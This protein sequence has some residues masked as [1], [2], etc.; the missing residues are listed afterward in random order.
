MRT[1]DLRAVLL[2]ALLLLSA[3]GLVALGLGAS[4]A[5]EA[6]AE[7]RARRLLSGAA[8]AL[9]DGLTTLLRDADD[10]ADSWKPDAGL[11]PLLADVFVVDG[12]GNLR[13]PP[14][15]H[16][17]PLSPPAKDDVA[18]VRVYLNE[19]EALDPA[20]AELLLQTAAFEELTHPDLVGVLVM[21]LA[22]R[23]AAEGNPDR[24][25]Y[26]YR[27]MLT[28]L[29]SAR[30]LDGEALAPVAHL[31]L[32]AM[33]DGPERVDA[34]A[35]FA[36]CLADRAWGLPAL[37]RELMLERMAEEFPGSRLPAEIA[38]RRE[39]MDAF[40]PRVLLLATTGIGEAGRHW[41]HRAER[42]NGV[43]EI[44]GW[45]EL[46][47]GGESHAFGYRV[48][49]TAA[50]ERVRELAEVVARRF[51][52]RVE[53]D[54]TPAV[55]VGV[56]PGENPLLSSVDLPVGLDAIAAAVA[57]ERP[58]DLG[59][60]RTLHVAMTL[61]L[62]ASLLAGIL[63]SLRAVRRELDTARLRQ[64]LL[65]NT[66]HELRTPLTTIRMY[67]EMLAEEVLPEEKREEYLGLVL[68][69]SERMGRLVDDVLDLAKLTRGESAGDP[70]PIAP[71]ELLEAAVARW[72]GDGVEID[73]PFG[74]PLVRADRD[75]TVRVLLNLI[76]NAR[77]YSEG[78]IRLSARQEDGAVDLTVTDRGPGIPESERDRLFQR[79]YRSPRDAR[80]VRGV[81][82]GLVLAREIARAQGGDLRLVE[83]SAEG[84]VF[85]LRLP[86]AGDGGAS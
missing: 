12:D 77:K 69:E 15:E 42:R 56:D 82:L 65:D 74:L 49:R 3:A 11:S 25:E 72:P 27:S 53:L 58:I 30:D 41:T 86:P 6:R 37:E 46:D 28:E 73:A 85:A 36:R 45:R 79:F 67:A 70:E 64:N 22:N 75:A 71:R 52:A 2:M 29:P 84:S 24:A 32:V 33:L 61:V 81:G 57:V 21:A 10:A 9:S 4:D 1:T 47:L 80:K 63:Y 7:L 18:R 34:A 55:A 14:A 76:D 54:T 60:L 5:A 48:A 23:S 50:G 31:R 43:V 44:F 66:S 26:R 16:F 68:S 59:G 38:R 13:H 35:A 62:A 78:D 8:T 39:F 83:T 51:R 40:L 17:P 19:A 20:A